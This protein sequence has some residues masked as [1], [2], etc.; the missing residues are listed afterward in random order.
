MSMMMI[1]DSANENDFELE[2]IMDLIDK[3]SNYAP[4]PSMMYAFLFMLVNSPRPM[5]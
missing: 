5:V 4:F 2:E 3:D 1:D